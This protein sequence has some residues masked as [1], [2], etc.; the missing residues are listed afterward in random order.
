MGRCMRTGDAH[1]FHWHGGGGDGGR[2]RTDRGFIYIAVLIAMAIIG[3]GLATA[4]IVWHTALQRERERQLLFVGDQFR[5][6]IGRYYNAGR[7]YPPRLEDLLR[8]PRLPGV[9]RYLRKIYYDPM[10]GTREWGLVKTSGDRIM[11]VYSLSEE[12]PIKQ[13]NFSDQDQ[14][15]EGKQKYSQWTFLYQP[16]RARLPVTGGAFTQPDAHSVPQGKQWSSTNY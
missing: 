7:Q 16:G 11:G 13:A 9:A 8:D 3:S 4:G 1:R 5:Q 2:L 14:A 6:A 10:T 15:F 12:K